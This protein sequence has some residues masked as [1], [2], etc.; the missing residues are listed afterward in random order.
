[1]TTRW[2]SS[3][4]KIPVSNSTSN[5]NALLATDVMMISNNGFLLD[6]HQAG[7][8][9]FPIALDGLDRMVE[10]L[11]SVH[12]YLSGNLVQDSS[13]QSTFCLAS[14]ILFTCKGDRSL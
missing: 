6:I 4:P 3:V 2:L 14:P 13:R 11:T 7:I 5:D 1:M 10:E 9:T 8:E 12:E